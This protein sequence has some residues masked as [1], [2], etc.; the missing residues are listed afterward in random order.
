M[1]KLLL[2]FAVLLLAGC[3]IGNVSDLVEDAQDVVSF[4]ENLEIEKLAEIVFVSPENGATEIRGKVPLTFLWKEPIFSLQ[5]HQGA[6]KFLAKNIT[7]TP[8]HEGEWKILG[9]TGISFEPKEDWTPSTH[10]EVKF[11]RDLVKDFSYSFETERVKILNINNFELVNRNPV[12]IS[13]NQEV[14][15]REISLNTK[16]LDAD[17]QEVPFDLWYDEDQDGNLLKNQLKLIPREKWAEEATYKIT[18]YPGD[19]SL[20]GNLLMEKGFEQKFTTAPKFQ[21]DEI[22]VPQ[23]DGDSANIRFSASVSS[24]KFAEFLEISPEFSAEEWDKYIKEWRENEYDSQYFYLNPPNGSWDPQQKFTIKIKKGLTDK[25]GRILTEDAEKSFQ[26]ILDTFFR[27]VYM[28]KPFSTFSR[29]TE[30]RPSFIF[31]GKVESVKVTL[32]EKSRDSMTSRE[33]RAVEGINPAT[34]KVPNFSR[35]FSLDSSLT[36]KKAW[37]INLKEEFPEILK[38]ENGETLPGKYKLVIEPDFPDQKWNPKFES[39][40]FISDFSVEMKK[41][42]NEKYQIFA[43]NYPNDKISRDFDNLNVEIWVGGWQKEHLYKSFKNVKNGFTFD[44]NDSSE[45][46]RTVVVYTEN[47]TGYVSPDFQDGISPWDAHIDFGAWEYSRNFAGTMFTDRPLYKPG[48]KLYL[49]GYLREMQLFGKNFPLK[50]PALQHSSGQAIRRSSGQAKNLNK[51]YTITVYDPQYNEIGK[52]TGTTQDGSFDNEFEIPESAKLGNYNLEFNLEDGDLNL[53]TPFWIQEYRK[54]NFLISAKFDHERAILDDEI[55]AGISAQYAFG[56]KIANRPVKYTVSLFGYEPCRWWCWDLAKK[57][58]VITSGEGMLDENGELEIPIDLRDLELGDFDWNLLTLNATIKVSPAEESSVEKSLPFFRANKILTIKDAPYFF[59]AENPAKISGEVRDL[60]EKLL[61]GEEVELVL[62]K[63][64]WVRSDRKNADGNFYGEWESVNEKVWD[65]EVETDDNGQF[66][67]DFT[68]PEEGGEYFFRISTEDEKSR[69]IFEKMFFWIADNDVSEVHKNETN[70]ILWMFP[71]KDKYEIGEEVEIF[72]PN[73]E[74][75]IT[76]AHATLERGEILEELDFDYDTNTVK[77]PAKKWMAP[78]VHVS[79]LLEGVDEKGNLKMKWGSH[80][81]QIHDPAHELQISVIPAPADRSFSEGWKKVYKPGEEAEFKITTKVNGKAHPAEVA[82]AVVDE[83]LLALKSRVK[84]DLIHDLIGELPLGVETFHTLAN[85]MSKQEMQEVLAEADQL[86]AKM[87][88]GFGGGGGKGDDFK[89]RGDFRDTAEFFAKIQTDENGEAVVKFKLPDNLTTWN[90]FAAG[91]TKDNAFGTTENNFQV[92]LPLLISEIV[93]NFFQAGDELKIGLL[94]HRN[95][96]KIPEEN[97]KVTLNLPPELEAVDRTEKTVSV[98]DEVRVYFPVKV[99][100]L[101]S[102]KKIEF[103]F[104]IFA[105]KS[106]VQDAVSLKREILPPSQVL[107]AAELLRVEPASADQNEE[108]SRENPSEGWKFSVLPDKNAIKSFFKV[109]IFASLVNYLENLVEI[110]Q[111]N[112]YGCAEQRFSRDS[113][114]M[115]QAELN[116]ILDKNSAKLDLEQIKKDRDYIEKAFVDGGFGY[117]ED[118][119]SPSFWVTTQILEHSDLWE[120]FEV[121]ISREKISQASDWLRREML[122]VCK[123]GDWTCP[124]DTSRENAAYALAK[125]GKLSVNDLEFLDEFTTTLEAKVWWL[126]SAK[127]VGNLS[128]KLEKSFAKHLEKLKEAFVIRDRYGFWKETGGRSFYSQ[129]ERL[130]AIILDFLLKNKEM[131]DQL[132]KI[133]RYLAES[134]KDFLSG[135]SAMQILKSLAEYVRTQEKASVGAEFVVENPAPADRS[136]NSRENSG[137]DWKNEVLLKGS[138]QNLAQ[139]QEYQTDDL[140]HE[141]QTIEVKTNKPVFAEIE[142]KDNLPAKF[143]RENSRGFWIERE[144]FP[145]E[146]KNPHRLAGRSAK[147]SV[148]NLELGKNYLVK[149]KIVTNSAHRQVLIEDPIPSGAEIVNFDLDN[150]DQTMSEIIDGQEKCVWGWCQPLFQHKEYRYDRARFFV[151]YLG[152]G[153]HEISYVLKT[154]LP[155]EFDWLPAQVKE[156]YYPEIFANTAGKRI[157]IE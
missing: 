4:T 93:P 113:G 152:A 145:L 105:E 65:K 7:L 10:Y 134:K 148:E 63:T 141:K 29:D 89:P 43:S 99:K 107:S 146:G 117:W 86:M 62:Y 36:E 16:L 12:K 149:I 58:K 78:N 73:P 137:E 121:G 59:Q 50:N 106:D 87:A 41:F 135:N 150:S 116:K 109:K 132:A 23:Y 67:F 5:N 128:P 53:S 84:V 130:T 34:V 83:T 119:S 9:T 102:A 51:K 35:E 25:Y 104:Q 33:G 140:G 68:T 32:N 155:G 6:Q 122:R 154:R 100:S 47:S 2:G 1:K 85:F 13:F 19:F 108:K 17:E 82:V 136:Q 44:I 20:G 24:K 101:D 96:A 57:D 74:F 114:M 126:K 92:T 28:P 110:S 125:H 115:Y 76:R 8:E 138:L 147:N 88:V 21:I 133:S 22:N 139:V 15:L 31:G 90:I 151:D 129:D 66:V 120:K 40:F 157:E 80:K 61:A 71:N 72:A 26:T 103:G 111:K 124:D 27:S 54:P 142:L 69:E 81:I 39:T 3:Q 60:D 153:T 49:K 11:S 118:S 131:T 30:I 156:M 98:K 143:V 56:G 18:I 70:K 52:I 64:K 14:K 97:I 46:L 79:I 123:D 94:I 48:Q 127:L 42:A 38:D 45:P 91:A 112:D 37:K 55:F 144:V 95:S 75:K 77:F